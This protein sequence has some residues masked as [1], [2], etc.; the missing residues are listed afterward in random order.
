MVYYCKQL[1]QTIVFCHRY[2]FTSFHFN[3]NPLRAFRGKNAFTAVRMGY[4]CLFL[5]WH[6]TQSFPIQYCVLVYSIVI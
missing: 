6:V 4:R 5:L 3:F 1:I 2:I